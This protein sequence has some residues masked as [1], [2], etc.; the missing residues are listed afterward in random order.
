MTYKPADV[1]LNVQAEWIDEGRN[2]VLAYRLMAEVGLRRNEARSVKWNDIDLQAGTLTTRSHWEGNKNGKEEVL[3]ITPGLHQALCAW[4]LAHPGP[5]D[6]EVVRISDRLLRCFDDDLV[7]AG[8][9]K[10][11]YVERN[12]IKIKRI[13][14]HDSAG[15][16]LDLH[17]LRHTF[18]T[19][20]GRMPGID[21]KSV[22]TLM[23]H[24]DPRMTFGIY[25]HSDRAR[26]QAAVA[27][28]PSLEVRTAEEFTDSKAKL[29]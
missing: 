1:P 16:V 11:V 29:A 28:L 21:P 5:D 8:L 18:G 4:R 22:Q 2:N 14:K 17:A 10:H 6:S 27:L 25:V 26:L 3:P 13:D 20:L 9:A 24:S 7:A 12:G 15:R 19:R 23:R